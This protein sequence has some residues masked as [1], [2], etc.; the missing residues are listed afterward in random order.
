MGKHVSRFFCFYDLV[1]ADGEPIRSETAFLV[2]S[3]RMKDTIVLNHIH[4]TI[5]G[6]CC[7]DIYCT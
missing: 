5:K 7:A 6:Q 3:K 2:M 4:V 1:S